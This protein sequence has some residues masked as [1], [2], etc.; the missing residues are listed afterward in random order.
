MTKPKADKDKPAKAQKDKA[1][2]KPAKPATGQLPPKKARKPK[3]PKAPEPDTGAATR[4]TKEQVDAMP[5]WVR[6][7]CTRKRKLVD[8]CRWQDVCHIPE[9]L[10][11][12]CD[13]TGEDFC[14]KETVALVLGKQPL[15]NYT[16]WKS[17]ATKG[18]L[19][20]PGRAGKGHAPGMG[21]GV[22]PEAVRCADAACKPCFFRFS[23]D[24]KTWGEC[25]ALAQS[26]NAVRAKKMDPQYDDRP[27]GARKRC[28]RLFSGKAMAAIDAKVRA[29]SGLPPYAYMPP[30]AGDATSEGPDEG[31]SACNL[32]DIKHLL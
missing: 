16:G 12:Y 25:A 10:K 29:I 2:E 9:I 22:L 7:G 30:D 28:V 32:D 5:E 11:K 19:V 31:A 21:F 4:A 23:A 20:A 6:K 27:E 3:S 14:R 8:Y 15:S 1:A 26:I 13:T 18:L 24:K 17:M